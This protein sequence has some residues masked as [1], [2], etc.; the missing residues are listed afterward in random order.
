MDSNNPAAAASATDATPTTNTNPAPAP[1][2]EQTNTPP[3]APQAP[4]FDEFEKFLQANGGKEKVFEK[5]KQAIGN[6]EE[7]ARS[8]LRQSQQAPAPQAP[9]PAAPAPEQPTTPA[10]VAP[11]DGQISAQE[12]FAKAYF[13][14][15]S[16]DPAYANIQEQLRNGEALK[17]M[18]KFNVPVMVSGNINDSK[19]R[20][21]MDM[22]SKSMPAKETSAPITNTPTVSYVEVPEQIATEADALK[23]IQQ[24]SE[25]RSSGQQAHPKYDEAVKFLQS[26][27]MA[28]MN[29]GVRQHT[30]PSRN[31]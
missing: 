1:N 18:E 2:T 30:I 8:I 22:Y 28:R 23:V 11:Q 13:D 9:A 14:S 3:A 4:E 12:F 24:S 25:L 31:K 6:P 7:Y 29:R 17:Q 19:I 27:G 5:M 15:L 21:F 10:S 16:N 26:K 20:E